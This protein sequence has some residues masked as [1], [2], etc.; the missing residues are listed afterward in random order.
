MDLFMGITPI[1]IR[2]QHY[3][4]KCKHKFSYFVKIYERKWKISHWC[5]GF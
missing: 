5:A 2:I 4:G 3:Y 1:A